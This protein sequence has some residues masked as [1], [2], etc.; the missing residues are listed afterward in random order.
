MHAPSFFTARAD[1][2]T[3][4]C[5]PM[6]GTGRYETGHTVRKETPCC[7]VF[8]R[9]RATFQNSYVLVMRV[10]MW[11]RCLPGKSDVH[12]L[13]KMQA[14]ILILIAIHDTVTADSRTRPADG[15]P[16]ARVAPD[17]AAGGPVHAV[18]RAVRLQAPPRHTHKSVCGRGPLLWASWHVTLFFCTRTDAMIQSVSCP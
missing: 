10:C 13:F 12:K 11:P 8:S 14:T 2:T 6:A 16:D 7:R 1:G 5:A 15:S 9:G 17:G 3:L 18:A 4:S